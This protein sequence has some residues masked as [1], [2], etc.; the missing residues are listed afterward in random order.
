MEKHLLLQLINLNSLANLTINY[1]H[2]NYFH[3]IVAVN[4]VFKISTKL[5]KAD[6][7]CV[8]YIQFFVR[9]TVDFRIME[10]ELHLTKN[11]HLYLLILY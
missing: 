10:V 1:F 6:Y 2:R 3:C 4:L 11:F 5:M 8:N 7:Y 9:M